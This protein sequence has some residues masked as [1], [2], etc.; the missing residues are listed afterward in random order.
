MAKG[1]VGALSKRD[2]GDR[3][4]DLD[5]NRAYGPPHQV[6]DWANAIGCVRCRQTLCLTLAGVVV[7]TVEATG[8]HFCPSGGIVDARQDLIRERRS[9]SSW[10]SDGNQ[11]TRLDR[12]LIRRSTSRPASPSI[13]TNV[14]SENRLI[15][16]RIRSEMRG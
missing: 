1:G 7:G 2:V 9:R 14:S 4:I 16:P 15:L 3:E 13:L 6:L 8:S 10:G 11:A 12:I 5:P